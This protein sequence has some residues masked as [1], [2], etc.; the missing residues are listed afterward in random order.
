MPK[1]YYLRILKDYESIEPAGF[2]EKIFFLLDY[3]SAFFRL[4]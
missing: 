2:L 1:K 3:Q 4:Y